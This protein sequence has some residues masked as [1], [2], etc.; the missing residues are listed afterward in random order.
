[1]SN[2]EANVRRWIAE[3]TRGFRDIEIAVVLPTIVLAVALL[4]V[5]L[6]DLSVFNNLLGCFLGL[7]RG[8]PLSYVLR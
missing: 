3:A 7:S 5:S 6:R 4:V 8:L 1:L 2:L